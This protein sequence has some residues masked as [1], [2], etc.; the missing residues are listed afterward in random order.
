MSVLSQ[1]IRRHHHFD[2]FGTEAFQT[3][4]VSYNRLAYRSSPTVYHTKGA[5]QSAKIRVYGNAKESHLAS[6]TYHN[7]KLEL[8]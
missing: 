2:I 4:M 6:L 3:G 8:L 7:S 1:G 5:K